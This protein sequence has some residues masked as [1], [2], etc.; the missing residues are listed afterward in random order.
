MRMKEQEHFACYKCGKIVVIPSDV[1]P[2]DRYGFE[3][4]E[5]GRERYQ[6]LKER[7]KCS[8][9]LLEEVLAKPE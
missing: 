4:T 6:K 1:L 5:E 8:S 3:M 9:C 7:G 2:G